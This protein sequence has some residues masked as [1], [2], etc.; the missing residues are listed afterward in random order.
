MLRYFN[1]FGPASGPTWRSPGSRRARDGRAFELYGDGAQSRSWTYVADIVDGDGR[2]DGARADG[3]YNVGGALEASMNEAIELFE[4]IAGR[5]LR[6]VRH[7]EPVAGDQRRTMA[8]TSRI[9]ADLGWEPRVS[10]EDGIA[11]QWQWASGRVNP[12]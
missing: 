9:R 10:L 4:R 6:V 5:E 8:D 1:A 11:A 3:T 2:G 12:R 7:D